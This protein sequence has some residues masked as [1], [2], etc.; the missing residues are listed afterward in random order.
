MDVNEQPTVIR[1]DEEPRP[2]LA[3]DLRETLR[4]HPRADRIYRTSVGAA[5]GAATALGVVLIPLPGPGAVIA[6]G[7]LA[8]LGTEFEGAR[9][10]N[11]KAVDLVK[12]GTE[13]VKRS[14]EKRKNAR[15]ERHA[16]G[17]PAAGAA[18][19]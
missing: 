3:R 5:G 12:R 8:L 4:R 10:V 14:V 1:I 19:G 7:G 15:A 17:H 16:A 18:A 13:Q 9:T 11:A 6:L 2:G